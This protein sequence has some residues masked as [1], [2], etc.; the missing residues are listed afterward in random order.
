MASKE[1]KTIFIE[2]IKQLTVKD[3]IEIVNGQKDAA[4]QYLEKTTTQS[5]KEKFNPNCFPKL[6]FKI[7]NSGD[8]TGIG[9]VLEIKGSGSF[10]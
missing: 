1:A 9:D 4:T 10:E 5:L 3:A 2:A 6:S 7:I 8:L